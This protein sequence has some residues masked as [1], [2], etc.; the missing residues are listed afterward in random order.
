MTSMKYCTIYSNNYLKPQTAE[1]RFCKISWNLWHIPVQCVCPKKCQFINYDSLHQNSHT[2]INI[3]WFWKPKRSF[4][5]NPQL[6][7]LLHLRSRKSNFIWYLLRLI[8]WQ[9][10]FIQ[11]RPLKSW[12]G[13]SYI[14]YLVD[15]HLADGYIKNL[16]RLTWWWHSLKKPTWGQAFL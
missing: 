13:V 10:W 7:E 12:R 8:L 3:Q 9:W 16:K 15:W 1:V 5:L 4:Q 6:I 2:V 14:S 11:K